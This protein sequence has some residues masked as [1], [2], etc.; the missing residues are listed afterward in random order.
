MVEQPD[1]QMQLP[2]VFFQICVTL[3]LLGVLA[4]KGLILADP[5]F[6]AAV[7]WFWLAPAILW[8]FAQTAWASKG[9]EMAYIGCYA[10]ALLLA[11]GIMLRQP[12]GWHAVV[13]ATPFA[14]LMVILRF[15]ATMDAVACCFQLAFALYALTEATKTQV[16]FTKVEL[17]GMGFFWLG[18]FIVSG[19]YVL[20][21]IRGSQPFTITTNLGAGA[22]AIAF[23]W[24]AV[25]FWTGGLG[26]V[27]TQPQAKDKG[28]GMEFVAI[29]ERKVKMK[30][31]AMQAARREVMAGRTPLGSWLLGSYGDKRIAELKRVQRQGGRDD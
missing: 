9:F 22:C 21:T 3:L 20:G 12:Q 16:P 6:T 28:E 25:T 31:A 18:Q 10:V 23:L 13:L 15:P 11:T 4:R 24:M 29:L 7:A 19:A 14:L 27:E 8:V 17:M 5:A 30:K 2:I 26:A 1:R